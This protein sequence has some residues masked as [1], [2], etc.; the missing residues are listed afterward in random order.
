MKTWIYPSDFS[1]CNPR[2][3]RN[4]LFAI[5]GRFPTKI[6][7]T[8]TDMGKFFWGSAANIYLGKVTEAF[9]KIPSSFG[10]VVTKPGLGVITHTPTCNTR[11]KGHNITEN[12]SSE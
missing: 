6:W 2:Y 9:Q 8:V 4:H 5:W 1:I 3:A 7:G 11:V 10:A 12:L